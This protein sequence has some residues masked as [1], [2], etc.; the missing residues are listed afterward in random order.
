MSKMQNI[1][2][3]FQLEFFEI[4]VQV[5]DSGSIAKVSEL[6]LIDPSGINRKI[7]ALETIC[8]VTLF[9]RKKYLS[10]FK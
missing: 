2:D 5:T 1:H 3:A 6:L 8:G 10:F 4:F 7:E 9:D